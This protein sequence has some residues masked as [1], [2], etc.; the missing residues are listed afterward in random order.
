MSRRPGQRPAPQRRAP[1]NRGGQY[2]HPSKFI[3]K[4][5][6]EQIAEEVFTPTQTFASMGLDERV[7]ANL[8]AMG[9]EF[10]TAIQDG[11]IPLII[12]GK[13]LV[14]LANTGTGKTAAFLLPL[15]H[16]IL[17]KEIYHCLLYTSPSPR[18]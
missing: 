8:K 10:P 13:D 15:I 16:R 3:N 14:G 7:V 5:S 4:A 12:E 18:D 2:I 9:I 1:N 6:V 17:K 11:S